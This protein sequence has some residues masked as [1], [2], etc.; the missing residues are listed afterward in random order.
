[1]QSDITILVTGC[2]GF[3]GKH[4][5]NLL[6][7]TGVSVICVVRDATK[8]VYSAPLT[9]RLNVI[10]GD[11]E[12]NE[13]LEK[14]PQSVDAVIHLAAVL[15]QWDADEEKIIRTNVDITERLLDWFSSTD[16]R[17]F[18]FVST[19]G[20][21]GFGH[22]Q[23]KEDE[24]YNPRG[25]YE[26]SKVLAE[27]SV[28]HHGYGAQQS[29]TILRPDFVYGPGDTRRVKLYRRINNRQWIKLGDGTSV[30][31]PTYV[32][33][34]CRA[35]ELC[36]LN[37]NAYGEIFNVAGPTL[38]TT[39]EFVDTIAEQI[40]APLPS[41]RI[42]SSIFMT[43]AGILEWVAKRS[44]RQPLFSKSQVEFLS[45]DHGTDISKIK[46][47]LGFVPPTSFAAGMRATIAWAKQEKLL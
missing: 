27:Q 13:T 19:P 9:E 40:G 7:S 43:A 18:L 1:M 21:Q 15:G 42:P 26:R 12:S 8:L 41:L 14:L 37:E 6:L 38:V 30:L 32:L 47:I 34:V 11:L 33:D 2:S 25:S 36:L 45:Q 29:W 16:S 17:Q 24:P 22:K 5:L 4:L 10:E 23:A 44:G 46:E 35:V 28:R 39:D 31:R 3:I 20:V